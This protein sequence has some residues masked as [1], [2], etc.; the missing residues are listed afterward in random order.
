M[1]ITVAFEGI[2]ALLYLSIIAVPAIGILGC[3]SVWIAVT[4]AG[5]INALIDITPTSHYHLLPL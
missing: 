3:Y 2:K 1:T 5:G 4:D